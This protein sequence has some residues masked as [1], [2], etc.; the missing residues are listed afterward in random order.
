MW[1]N[2]VVA[3]FSKSASNPKAEDR[4]KPKGKALFL[5]ECRKTLRDLS[6]SRKEMYQELMVGIASDPL[7]E[8]LGWS[9]GFAPSG[10][11]VMFP[12]NA[13]SLNDWAYKEGLADMPECTRCGKG[14]EQTAVHTFYY[15]ERVRPFWS[16]VGELTAR[17]EPN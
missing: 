1:R 4:R 17:I 15:C 6:R 11:G 9:Q 7:V 3:A 10:I 16:H 8:Q 14:V 12:R 2:K 13:L 5:V